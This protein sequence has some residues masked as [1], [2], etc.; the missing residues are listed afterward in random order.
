MW[1]AENARNEEKRMNRRGVACDVL[2]G[3]KQ[4]IGVSE[5]GTIGSKSEAM[6]PRFSPI[7]FGIGFPGFALRSEFC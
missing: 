1:I 7:Q 5:I 2:R 6:I 4:R 3:R